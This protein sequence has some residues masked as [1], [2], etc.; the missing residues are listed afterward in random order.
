MS[1]GDEGDDQSDSAD[2]KTDLDGD[3]YFLA[4]PPPSFG[5]NH[6]DDEAPALP[7]PPPSR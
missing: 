6:H 4:R 7:C 2:S 1:F 5:T 3:I